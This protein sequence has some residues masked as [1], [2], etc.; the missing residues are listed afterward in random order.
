MKKQLLVYKLSKLKQ[1]LTS[2]LQC[3]KYHFGVLYSFHPIPRLEWN[4][5]SIEGLTS[6]YTYFPNGIWVQRYMTIQ[7]SSLKSFLWDL[8]CVTVWQAMDGRYLLSPLKHQNLLQNIRFLCQAIW[9]VMW[10][11]Y[12]ISLWNYILLSYCNLESNDL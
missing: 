9:Y 6:L 7:L 3:L 2:L 11:E 1:L 10:Q 12:H 4:C 8:I 5:E